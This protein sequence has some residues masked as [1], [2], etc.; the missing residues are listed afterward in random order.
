MQKRQKMRSKND[1]EEDENRQNPI[2]PKIGVELLEY[3]YGGNPLYVQ[4][5]IENV[6]PEWVPPCTPL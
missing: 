6:H 1:E 2:Y 4:P 5:S 3:N